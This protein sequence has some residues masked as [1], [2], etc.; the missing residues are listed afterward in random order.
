MEMYLLNT[1]IIEVVFR[2]K[3]TSHFSYNPTSQITLRSG[4]P[5]MEVYATVE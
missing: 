5:E 2:N 4:A 1:L 3:M